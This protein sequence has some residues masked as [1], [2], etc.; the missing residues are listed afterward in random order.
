MTEPARRALRAAIS[1]SEEREELR[2]WSFREEARREEVSRGDIVSYRG[3]EGKVGD[4]GESA[5]GN[6]RNEESSAAKVS[7]G[8]GGEGSRLVDIG[9]GRFVIR[10][11]EISNAG[12]GAREED[13]EDEEGAVLGLRRGAEVGGEVGVCRD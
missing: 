3:W 8:E 9:E 6:I 13:E 7:R 4:V 10:R 1:S 2:E 11:G 5:R 12:K